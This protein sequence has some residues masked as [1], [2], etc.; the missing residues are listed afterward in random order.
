MGP[1]VG[2]T[3]LEF[4]GLGP[5]PFAALLLSDMGANVITIHRVSET[6]P[7]G[8]NSELNEMT[9]GAL[10]R[11][12]RS[13]AVDLK[14]P[15]GIETVLSLLA[16]A[17]G[18][19]EGFRP[20]VMERL[21]L[22][23]D[24]CWKRN[25]RLVY[26]RMTGWGQLGKLARTAGHD[27]NYIAIAGVLD[28]VGPAGAPM[29][30]LNL[31]GD[32]GGGGLL[33]AFGMAAGL[34]EATRSGTGQVV[35]AAMV[36]GSSLLMTMMYELWGRQ[37]WDAR[38]ESNM[39]DGG[40]H[41]YNI[42]ETLDGKHVTIAAME[43]AFYAILVDLIGLG[44]EQLPDQWDKSTWAGMKT[45][46]A[47]VFRTK[48]RADW[49]TLL[50]GTDACYAPVLSMDEAVSH[51]RNV[52]RSSFVEVDGILQPAPAPR[53]SRTPATVSRGRASP[54]EHTEEVLLEFGIDQGT[55]DGLMSSGAVAGMASVLAETR[56]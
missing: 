36:D 27:V 3:I 54:G 12:R 33:L 43:P 22:G 44:N 16:S 55:I 30:P 52:E 42:Y 41:F 38:R 56:S 10:A 21:G 1:L 17:D 34:F 48:T 39:N 29:V 51:P 46:F 49:S 7:L 19:I 14:S 40:A 24:A 45:R 35:D 9:C 18:L 6:K 25:P 11:G 5:T 37:Q 15:D 23:P 31:I 4:A 2:V 20:G 32:F 53:F 8:E 26:G 47:A 50:D 13:I 28:H